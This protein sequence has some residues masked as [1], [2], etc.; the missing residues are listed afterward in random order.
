MPRPTTAVTALLAV[1]LCLHVAAAS[2]A[3]VVALAEH[4]QQRSI[5]L[6]HRSGNEVNAVEEE[7]PHRAVDKPTKF[8]L[9]VSQYTETD[10]ESMYELERRKMAEVSTEAVGIIEE[11]MT[12]VS[13]GDVCLF[14][15]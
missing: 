2:G 14:F 1:A 3:R 11:K 15:A 7:H 8:D 10:D 6:E 13:D 9:D 12:R 5:D 4:Q